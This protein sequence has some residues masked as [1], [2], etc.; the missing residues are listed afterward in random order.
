MPTTQNS[1]LLP[2]MLQANSTYLDIDELSNTTERSLRYQKYGRKMGLETPLRLSC[3]HVLGHTYLIYLVSTHDPSR[4]PSCPFCKTDFLNMSTDSSPAPPPL[5]SAQTLNGQWNDSSIVPVQQDVGERRSSTPTHQEPRRSQLIQAL[6]NQNN[7]VSI[8]E[9]VDETLE[10]TLLLRSQ[11]PNGQQSTSLTPAASSSR[12]KNTPQAAQERPSTVFSRIIDRRWRAGT[13]RRY[14]EI[15]VD[16]EMEP[17][18]S[19]SRNQDRI[20][21]KGRTSVEKK[22]ETWAE[23]LQSIRSDETPITSDQRR[24]VLRTEILWLRLIYAARRIRSHQSAKII[25]DHDNIYSIWHDLLDDDD[26]EDVIKNITILEMQL[27]E[28]WRD[29]MEHLEHADESGIGDVEVRDL[30]LNLFDD[31]D[32]RPWIFHESY[33]LKWKTIQVGGASRWSRPSR[34]T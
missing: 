9:S 29:L 26:I 13:V 11:T 22:I 5:P 34:R 32:E 16:V 2:P 19:R 23:G 28:P 10:S 30:S 8:D 12:S 17:E 24:W 4:F 15:K 14:G 7:T 31:W 21:N 25:L 6:S 33:Q 20:D 18:R 27:P 1:L 3:G